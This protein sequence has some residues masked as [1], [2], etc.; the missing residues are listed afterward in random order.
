MLFRSASLCKFFTFILISL[1]VLQNAIPK[2][3]FIHQ[4]L[5]T[6]LFFRFLQIVFLPLLL[7]QFSFGMKLHATLLRAMNY[8]SHQ[9]FL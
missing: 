2:S 6:V 1:L 4:Y 8:W 7:L 3:E 5:F 9:K